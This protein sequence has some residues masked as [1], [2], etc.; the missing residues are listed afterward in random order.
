LPS[1][2]RRR[3][4]VAGA[5]LVV[6]AAC[7]PSACAGRS[8]PGT[9]PLPANA[10]ASAETGPLLVCAAEVAEEVGLS[11]IE[12]RADRGEL[13]A[14]SADPHRGGTGRLDVVTVRIG[15]KV[16]HGVR[17]LAQT[18]RRRAPRGGAGAAWEA[19]RPSLE[20]ALARDPI[21]QRCGTLDDGPRR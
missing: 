7:L 4:P 21:L 18:F 16:S 11:V 13:R 9:R 19:E 8:A 20:A 17:V 10:R 5:L 6:S 1:P 2:A 14:L 15:S 12:R 3:A